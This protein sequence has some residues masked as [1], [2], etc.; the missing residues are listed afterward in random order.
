[1]TRDPRMLP[2]TKAGGDRHRSRRPLSNRA[3]ALSIAAAALGLAAAVVVPAYAVSNGDPV[4]EGQYTY[5]VKLTMPLITS[6]ST[7][8]TRSSACSGALIARQWIVSA[9]HCFHDG[10]RHKINGAPHY[11]I[12]VTAGTSNVDSGLGQ[13][14]DVVDV[15]QAPNG[16]DLAIAKLASPVSGIHP[17][18]VAANPPAVGTVARIVGFG[19]Y[20]TGSVAVPG[21]VRSPSTQAYTGTVKVQDVTETEVGMADDRAEPVTGCLYDSGAPYVVERG[22]APFLVSVE[23][24]GPT[25]PHNQREITARA[26]NLH[27]WIEE[28]IGDED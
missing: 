2:Q 6:P 1:M 16:A 19:W 26:D 7:G 3:K 25:C 28:I 9:G 22:G 5:A 20:T 27:D 15:H 4:A 23:S 11:Q 12:I 10:D 21:A 13:N 18:H 24:D 14:V 8:A 17:L